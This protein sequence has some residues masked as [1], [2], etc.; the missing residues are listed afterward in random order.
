VAASCAVAGTLPLPLP[1]TVTV[2]RPARADGCDPRGRHTAPPP[3][4]IAGA[5]DPG[6]LAVSRAPATRPSLPCDAVTFVLSA[7]AWAC[8]AWPRAWSRGAWQARDALGCDGAHGYYVS[9][10]LPADELTR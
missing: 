8:V 9:R 4:S 3:R 10:A 1:W 7:T 5:G 2:V 6:G